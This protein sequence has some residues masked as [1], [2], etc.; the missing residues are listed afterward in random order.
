ME[1]LKK[2]IRSHLNKVTE[3]NV[4]QIARAT[5]HSDTEVINALN[6]MRTYG[7]VE[8]EQQGRGK[9]MMY[10]LA[11]VEDPAGGDT[12]CCNAAKVMAKTASAEVTQLRKEIELKQKRID[13]LEAVIARL[14]LQLEFIDGENVEERV[15]QVM[16]DRIH[17]KSRIDALN[18]ELISASSHAAA[19][20]VKS[21][22]KGYLV[23][24]PKRKPVLVMKP[25]KAVAKAVSAAKSAGRSE[26]FA[27]VPV[28][29]AVE[30]RVKQVEYRDA[31]GSSAMKGG[32]A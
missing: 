10:W 30:K 24:A 3:S 19:I 13:D 20:D 1:E 8:C 4:K 12:P 26:V 6:A 16:H 7:E 11:A 27:M 5:G 28:G 18:Q 29:A 21:V 9:G 25:E 14:M 2:L 22:A 31:G 32:T 23:R 15:A 17:D